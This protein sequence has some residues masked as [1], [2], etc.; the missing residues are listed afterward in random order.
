MYNVLLK[1]TAEHAWWKGAVFW[2]DFKSKE[3]FDA[4]YDEQRRSQYE[5]MEEGI[6]RRRAVTLCWS[7][8]DARNLT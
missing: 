7:P 2:A 3:Q 1:I 8:K 4:W 6:S 5:I